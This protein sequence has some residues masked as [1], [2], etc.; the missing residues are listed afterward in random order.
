[1]F[2]SPYACAWLSP[3][4]T[5][6]NFIYSRTTIHSINIKYIIYVEYARMSEYH[7]ADFNL[8]TRT[9]SCTCVEYHST[10]HP[11]RVTSAKKCEQLTIYFSTPTTLRIFRAID[12]CAHRMYL[13]RALHILF[14]YQCVYTQTKYVWRACRLWPMWAVKYYDVH[15]QRLSRPVHQGN[16]SEYLVFFLAHFSLARSHIQRRAH[17]THP[18][19]QKHVVC[20]QRRS[21]SGSIK[22][23]G[24]C[25]DFISKHRPYHKQPQP[26]TPK[27]RKHS[28][29]TP[30]PV[31]RF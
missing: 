10:C 12:I 23:R 28:H 4:E 5:I 16:N 8:H 2:C 15:R 19:T 21:A 29:H 27:T 7:I 24:A 9:S 11:T 14:P 3:I 20:C 13:W 6:S 25:L 26:T 18:H 17:H 22:C 1:M 31:Y 30:V